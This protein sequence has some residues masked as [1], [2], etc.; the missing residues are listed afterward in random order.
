MELKNPADR[1]RLGQKMRVPNDVG[2]ERRDP[3]LLDQARATAI[4]HADNHDRGIAEGNHFAGSKNRW[5]V[6]RDN[7][8]PLAHYPHNL[9]NFPEDAE[10]TSSLGES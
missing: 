1:T 8:T 7:C 6:R 5:N 10:L 3:N 4:Y 9:K 2:L